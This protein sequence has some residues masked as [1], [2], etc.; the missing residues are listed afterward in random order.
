MKTATKRAARPTAPP[1]LRVFHGPNDRAKVIPP[2]VK[3][4]VSQ[5]EVCG[6]GFEVQVWTDVEWARLPVSKRPAVTQIQPGIGRIEIRNV[7]TTKR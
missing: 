5:W 7:P 3:P 6:H 1:S 2:P 4:S